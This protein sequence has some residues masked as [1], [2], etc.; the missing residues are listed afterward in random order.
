MKKYLS[1]IIIFTVLIGIFHPIISVYAA[2]TPEYKLLA[3]LPCEIGK[4]I[5]CELIDGKPVLKTFNPAQKNNLGFYLNLMIKIFIG[6]CAV[7]SVVMIV[8]GGIEV[9]TSELVHTK[10]AGK[11]KIRNA[12]LGLLLALGAYVL[13]FTINPNLLRSDLC[14]SPQVMKDGNCIDPAPIVP[15]LSTPTAPAITPFQIPNTG[16]NTNSPSLNP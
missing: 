3:P 2:T 15:L 14:I 4:D 6:L 12:L 10:E 9:M 13:L 16:S 1:H 5:G 7:L 11:E 8:I